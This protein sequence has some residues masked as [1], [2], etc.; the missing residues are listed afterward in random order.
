MNHAR[1]LRGLKK[2]RNM[3]NLS[4]DCVEE[5]DVHDELLK[6]AKVCHHGIRL[7]RQLLKENDELRARLVRQACYFEHIEAKQEPRQWPLLNDD[8]GEGL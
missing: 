3:N 8:C 5:W 4:A 1:I 7:I 6:N 2:L